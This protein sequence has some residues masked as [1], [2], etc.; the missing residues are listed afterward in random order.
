MLMPQM[1]QMQADRSSVA[2]TLLIKAS[3]QKHP[4]LKTPQ[5][6]CRIKFHVVKEAVLFLGKL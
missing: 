2:F 6:L 3:M 5:Y 1:S 4:L